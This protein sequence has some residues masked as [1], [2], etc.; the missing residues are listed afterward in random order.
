MLCRLV[1]YAGGCHHHPFP[2]GWCVTDPGAS[3]PIPNAWQASQ[4][5]EGLRERAVLPSL[6]FGTFSAKQAAQRSLARATPTQGTR[7]R[8]SPT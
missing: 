3:A 1:G 5:A 4:S 8:A 2:V 7:R 6:H